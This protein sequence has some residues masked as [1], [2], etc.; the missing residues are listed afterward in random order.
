VSRCALRVGQRLAECVGG[1]PRTETS[2][3]PTSPAASR[4][5]CQARLSG[6]LSWRL[7]LM[8]RLALL[9]AGWGPALV[10]TRLVLLALTEEVDRLVHGESA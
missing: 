1:S 3:R 8:R 4:V 10:E 5:T 9:R 2:T 6:G 7:N